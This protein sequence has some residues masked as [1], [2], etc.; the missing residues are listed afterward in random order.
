MYISRPHLE[1]E[2]EREIYGTK[3]IIIYGDSGCGKSWLYKKVLSDLKVNYKVI[4]LAS[5]ARQ[6]S[7]TQE[8]RSVLSTAIPVQKIGYTEKKAAELSAGIAKGQVD[9]VA[10]YQIGARDPVEVLFEHMH[11]GSR[12]K[13]SVIVFENLE[14][15]FDNQKLMDELGNL[16]I[17]LDDER[18]A[19]FNVKFIIVGVPSGVV[20]YFSKVKNLLSISNRLSE[21]PEV[22]RLS[23]DQIS[24]FVRTGLLD[25]LN[26]RFGQGLFNLFEE[27]IA[28]V[29]NGF[30]QRLHEYCL[31]LSEMCEDNNWVANERFLYDADIKWARK[32]HSKCVAVIDNIMNSKETTV[33]RRNQVLYTIAQIE[34]STFTVSDVEKIIKREFPNSTQDVN[35]NIS[36]TLRSISQYEYSPIKRTPKGNS[37]L[38]SDPAYLLCLRSIL[39]KNSHEK[40]EKRSSHQ[41]SRY[42][43]LHSL[44]KQLHY[45]LLH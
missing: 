14:T 6:Q 31:V 44:H 36:G 13:T 35:L 4:N 45:F 28:W 39:V 3:H 27:H 12:M 30:P 37:W 25:E 20:E 34:T 43:D 2:L 33:G 32:S 18:Y 7:I 23:E 26:I 5:A 11:S 19:R 38:F 15:I 42:N 1:K 9:H 8:F 17:L 41:K 16:I 22:S 29:T 24:T 40:V 21:V 10:S